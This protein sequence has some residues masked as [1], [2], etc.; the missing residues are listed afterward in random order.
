MKL[1]ATLDPREL[2]KLPREIRTRPNVTQVELARKLRIPNQNISSLEVGGR[3]GMLS[4]IN[5][6]VRALGWELILVARP[7]NA[8]VDDPGYIEP[9]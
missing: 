1:R 8:A 9:R 3:E 4:T 2:G 6:I 7:R 5:R